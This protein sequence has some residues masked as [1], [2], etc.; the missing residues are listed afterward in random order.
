MH[1]LYH[2][3][4]HNGFKRGNRRKYEACLHPYATHARPK[5]WWYYTDEINLFCSNKPKDTNV[6]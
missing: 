3:H 4:P 5:W 2:K 1:A 6:L